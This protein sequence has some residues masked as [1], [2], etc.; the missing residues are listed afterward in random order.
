VGPADSRTLHVGGLDRSKVNG[1]FLIAA[2]EQVDG[3]RRLVG[4]EPVLS[5]W[6]VAGCANCQ[7][8]LKASADFR[9]TPEIA[10]SKAIGVEIHTR[11]GVI[12][13]GPRTHSAGLIAAEA[14]ELPFSVEIR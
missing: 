1:S 12:G 11:T 4:I 7:N 6:H 13:G 14:V 5:R 8:H 10:E 3:E 9:I 2:Y